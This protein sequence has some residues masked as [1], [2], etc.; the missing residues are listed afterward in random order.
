MSDGRIIR[1]HVDHLRE[2]ASEGTP[3]LANEEDDWLYSGTTSDSP[4][5]S[6]QPQLR[7]STRMTHP[8]DWF[9]F[10]THH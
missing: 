6:I 1:R 8:T 5:I 9:R 7:R 10:P 2:R 3:S 4:D